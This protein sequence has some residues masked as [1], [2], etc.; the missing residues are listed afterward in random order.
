MKPTLKLS[1]LIY[2][3]VISCHT[4][5]NKAE[6]TKSS[7]TNA[8]V[9]MEHDTF[10]KAGY[11][12]GLVEFNEEGKCVYTITDQSTNEVYD[13]VNFMEIAEDD[14]K[15]DIVKVYYKFRPLR[16]M[17]RCDD[18]QPIEITEIKKRED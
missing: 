14:L 16:M 12:L 3:L 7:N 13:P 1:L 17:N 10:I 18:L 11:K 6:S 9:N 2:L 4:T 5:K 15:N 8:S